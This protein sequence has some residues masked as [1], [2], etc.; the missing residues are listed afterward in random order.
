MKPNKITLLFA[1]AIVAGTATAAVALWNKREF[2]K[3]TTTSK[4]KPEPEVVSAVFVK[5]LVEDEDNGT[6]VSE[7]SESQGS[8]SDR[9]S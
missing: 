8:S 1:G 7:H 2:R 9:G 6:E 4:I 5:P 3:R